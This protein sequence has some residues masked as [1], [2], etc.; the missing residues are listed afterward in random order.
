MTDIP[1][2]DKAHSY[3]RSLAAPGSC[4]GQKVFLPH[5]R[6]IENHA[7]IF[8]TVCYVMLYLLRC[9]LVVYWGSIEL[10]TTRHCHS[11]QSYSNSS[12]KL[13]ALL[14]RYLNVW[15]IRAEVAEAGPLQLAGLQV[16]HTL[17]FTFSNSTLRDS[18]HH[19]PNCFTAKKT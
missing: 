8:M 4:R 14:H 10:S 6:D 5:S 11:V 9:D 3:T 18:M 13:I 17:V 16:P 7:F 15:E 1:T 2:S 19:H 12:W